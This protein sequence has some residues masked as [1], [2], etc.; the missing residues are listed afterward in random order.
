MNFK[1]TSI[2][3]CHPNEAAI[4]S[5]TNITADNSQKT[6]QFTS[7]DQS[8]YS[9][10]QQLNYENTPAGNVLGHDYKIKNRNSLLASMETSADSSYITKENNNEETKVNLH[11]TTDIATSPVKFI[12]LSPCYSEM[13]GTRPFSEASINTTVSSMDNTISSRQSL[14]RVSPES[15]K[16]NDNRFDYSKMSIASDSKIN[17]TDKSSR[18]INK[19]EETKC[20]DKNWSSLANNYASKENRAH[21][22]EYSLDSSEYHES[23]TEYLN[24]VNNRLQ[25][26]IK[27]SLEKSKRLSSIFKLNVIESTKEVVHSNLAC[28]VSPS[29]SV[30]SRNETKLNFSSRENSAKKENFKNLIE[31]PIKA[32]IDH[33]YNSQR[34]HILGPIENKPEILKM[35]KQSEAATQTSFIAQNNNLK[36]MQQSQ[37]NENKRHSIGT[38]FNSIDLQKQINKEKIQE[39]INTQKQKHEK[40]IKELEKLAELERIQAEKL[41]NIMLDSHDDTSLMCNSFFNAEYATKSSFKNHFYS[42]K[43]YNDVSEL[44]DSDTTC[45][46]TLNETNKPTVQVLEL[47]NTTVHEQPSGVFVVKE[48]SNRNLFDHV[49]K[50]LPYDRRRTEIYSQKPNSPIIDSF[51]RVNKISAIDK[52]TKR[53]SL[54]SGT[55]TNLRKNVGLTESFTIKNDKNAINMSLQEAFETFRCDLISRSRLRQKEIKFRAEQRQQEA[56]FRRLNQLNQERRLS[57]QKK[58]CLK[59]SN[60]YVLLN[61][62]KSSDR[63]RMSIQDIKNQNRKLYDKLPEVKQ[64]QKQQRMEEEKRLNRMKTSIFKKVKF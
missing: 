44:T 7:M 27:N 18:S 45:Q 5:M 22:N 33:K 10:K 60:S 12:T 31:N 35:S 53:M 30:T 40:R 3:A 58:S 25:N 17:I 42:N 21:S 54:A 6:K 38:S 28:N 16:Q 43:L 46:T 20:L 37:K 36:H 15:F 19:Q 2:L 29:V 51:K 62:E 24:P 64:K 48:S 61:M 9:K 50:S 63:R 14:V 26:L 4:N 49:T 59:K 11:S 55:K 13:N 8:S 41:K 34:E 47:K 52:A 57:E 23:D 39:L 1:S 32:L 56:E